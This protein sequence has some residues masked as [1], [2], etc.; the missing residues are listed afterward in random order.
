MQ[1]RKENNIPYRTK[2]DNISLYTF[3]NHNESIVRYWSSGQVVSLIGIPS[4]ELS[5]GDLVWKQIFMLGVGRSI[6]LFYIL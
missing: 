5:P 2:A 6:I 3:K 1:T 4:I